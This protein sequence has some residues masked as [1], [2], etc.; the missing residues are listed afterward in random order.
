[1]SFSPPTDFLAAACSSPSDKLPASGI[2]RSIT[3]WGMATSPNGHSS[4]SCLVGALQS[5]PH[6]L[7]F[8][9]E[10]RPDGLLGMDSPLAD[11]HISARSGRL[12]NFESDHF[13]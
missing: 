4:R 7:L 6:A 13:Q 11:S 8:Y 5:R 3:N 9:R 12:R 2:S 10:G 1:M